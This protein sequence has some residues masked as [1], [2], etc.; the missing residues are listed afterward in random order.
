MCVRKH[1]RGR[2]SGAWKGGERMPR[3]MARTGF[4]RTAR[5]I[6]KQIQKL[7]DKQGMSMETYRELSHI[8]TRLQRMMTEGKL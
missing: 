3:T 4:K 6:K 8:E 1:Y 2:I 7:K 5:R